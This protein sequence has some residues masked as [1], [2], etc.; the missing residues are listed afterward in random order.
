M[1][2]ASTISTRLLRLVPQ[3]QIYNQACHTEI[4]SF[5]LLYAASFPP[6]N[7]A[8]GEAVVHNQGPLEIADQKEQ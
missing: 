6:E 1:L 2:S 8:T 3:Q 7:S 5:Y 4:N